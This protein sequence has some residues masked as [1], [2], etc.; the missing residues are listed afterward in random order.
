MLKKILVCTDGSED[1]RKAVLYA[2]AFSKAL[3]FP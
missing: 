2:S 3:K 1:S